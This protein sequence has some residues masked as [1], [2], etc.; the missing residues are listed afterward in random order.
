MEVF[1]SILLHFT[2]PFQRLQQTHRS[3]RQKKKTDLQNISLKKPLS[4]DASDTFIF[5]FL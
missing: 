5:R 4:R 3:H 2:Y 1:F